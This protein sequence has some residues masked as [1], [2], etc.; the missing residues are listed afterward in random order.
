MLKSKELGV[1]FGLKQFDTRTRAL[2]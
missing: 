1:S 2:Q